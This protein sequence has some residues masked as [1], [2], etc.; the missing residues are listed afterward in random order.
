MKERLDFDR[1]AFQSTE[2]TVNKCVK[3]TLNV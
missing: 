3:F 1:S 2:I